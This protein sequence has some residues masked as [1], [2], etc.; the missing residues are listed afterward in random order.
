[1]RDALIRTEICRVMSEM[2]DNPD[3]HGIYP[4]TKFM[5][6]LEEYCLKLRHE[7]IGWTWAKACTQLDAGNDPRQY[8]QAQLIQDASRDLSSPL[9]E[10]TKG[11][12]RISA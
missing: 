5:D 12:S 11:I 7:A 10:N 1:M 4:T 6:E 2:L 3:E 8:D 9:E